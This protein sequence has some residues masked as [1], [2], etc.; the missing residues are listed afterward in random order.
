MRFVVRLSVL[1]L[2][3]MSALAA[4]SSVP[5]NAPPTVAGVDLSR[6]IGV[7]HEVAEFP[8]WF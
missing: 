7:W 2:A 8:A 4:C 1:S 3:L 6:Y 5:E